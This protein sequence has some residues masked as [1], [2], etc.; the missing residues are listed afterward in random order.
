[1][2]ALSALLTCIK[3]LRIEFSELVL[4]VDVD[5]DVDADVDD[6]V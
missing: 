6:V 2:P 4:D 3:L 5:V 1:V